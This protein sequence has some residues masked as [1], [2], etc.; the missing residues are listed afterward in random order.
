VT[1]LRREIVPRRAVAYVDKPGQTGICISPMPFIM[2]FGFL[3]IFSRRNG[4]SNAMQLMEQM[5]WD[6]QAIEKDKKS[7]NFFAAAP[8]AAGM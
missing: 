4:I 7:D 6:A 3:T 5:R 8:A 1:W 2:A